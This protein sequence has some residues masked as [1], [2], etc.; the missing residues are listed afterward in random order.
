MDES[1]LEK[2][3]SRNLFF[4]IFTIGGNTNIKTL[5][6]VNTKTLNGKITNVKI[7]SSAQSEGYRLL[8]KLWWQP[9]AT[10]WVKTEH[11]VARIFFSVLFVFRT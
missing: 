4:I 11:F 1:I 10:R 2:P 9:Y 6:G 3:I 7:T 5:N 8:A